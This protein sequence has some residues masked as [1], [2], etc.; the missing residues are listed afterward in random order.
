VVG[1]AASGAETIN[2]VSKLSPDIL[3]LDMI[4]GDI[5]G[6]EVTRHVR[7]ES[8]VTKVVFFSMYGDQN[9]ILEAQQLGAK[10]YVLKE[11]P[12]D[13]LLRAIGVVTKGGRHFAVPLPPDK[14]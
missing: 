9:Y 10:G 14:L 3:I 6:L 2:L 11:S 7:K 5:T 8:P 4:L 13:E 12:A 1:E